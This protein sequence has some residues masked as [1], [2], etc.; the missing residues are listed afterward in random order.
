M[1]LSEYF[2]FVKE[3]STFPVTQENLYPFIALRGEVGEVLNAWKKVLRKGGEITEEVRQ[4]MKDE[5]GDVLWYYAACSFV[6]GA[7]TEKAQSQEISAI[8]TFYE[9]DVRDF[10]KDLSKVEPRFP[11]SLLERPE[12]HREISYTLCSLFDF[13]SL[14]PRKVDLFM[15]C[16]CTAL[17]YFDLTLEEVAQYNMDKLNQRR[18]A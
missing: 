15:V 8:Q 5:L 12:K 4:T 18:N 17:S 3:T 6:C 16:L 10:K 2:N 14:F 11:T 9:E 13:A 1:K 7:N